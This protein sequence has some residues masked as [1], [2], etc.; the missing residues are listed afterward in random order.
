MSYQPPAAQP[1]ST[2]FGPFIKR[3]RTGGHEVPADIDPGHLRAPLCVRSQLIALLSARRT[4]CGNDALPGITSCKVDV[5]P[6]IR[7][8]AQRTCDRADR[9]QISR[10][11]PLA[12]STHVT[13]LLFSKHMHIVCTSMSVLF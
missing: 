2:A 9:E 4:V 6:C 8:R 13:L 3:C 10:H 5:V 7:S 1:F 11:S 12:A